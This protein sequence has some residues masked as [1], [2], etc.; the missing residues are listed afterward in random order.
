[1]LFRVINRI[2]LSPD[3]ILT[4]KSPMLTVVLFCVVKQR[5]NQMDWSLL[6]EFA[7]IQINALSGIS[8]SPTYGL[9]NECN[10]AERV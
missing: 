7:L 6:K 9:G 5:P 1:M 4:L 3:L 8:K 2:R 10:C